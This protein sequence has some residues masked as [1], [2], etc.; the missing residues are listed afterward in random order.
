M[1][2]KFNLHGQEY[3]E[4]NRILKLLGLVATGGE[5]K[6]IIQQGEVKVNHMVETQVR[7]KLR[8][9]DKIQFDDATIEIL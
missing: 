3:I 6:V 2:K 7:K 8:S 9:G 5:A 4:L 1:Y